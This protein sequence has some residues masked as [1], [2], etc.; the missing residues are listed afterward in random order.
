MKTHG[1][2]RG[3]PQNAAPEYRV[4]LHIRG[5]CRTPTD[6]AYR[7]YGGRGI[8][9]SPA[10]D[11]YEAFLADVGPRPTSKHTLDRLDNEKGYEPGNCG[12]RTMKEQNRN[13]RDNRIVSVEGSDM[14]LAEA[15]ER[16]RINYKT[17]HTRIQRDGWDLDR[18]LRTPPR[19]RGSPTP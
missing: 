8:T 17:V 6:A 7:W 3:W 11:S 5:R 14:S 2:A 13:R 9:L 12:W 4:W 16:A 15:C 10:W 18:A 1:A 19:R